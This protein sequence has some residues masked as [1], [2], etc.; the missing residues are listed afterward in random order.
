MKYTISGDTLRL[1]ELSLKKN[2]NV[3][4]YIY[5]KNNDLRGITVDGG[6]VIVD[7]FNQPDLVIEQSAGWLSVQKS[8]GLR[9]ISL[10]ATNEATFNATELNLDKFSVNADESRI[11]VW[12]N[13]QRLEGRADNNSFVRLY[14]PEDIVFKKDKTSI[15]SLTQGSFAPEVIVVGGET[16]A[17]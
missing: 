9:T 6:S 13:V 16:S 14:S 2:Q 15:L 7:Q 4:I 3:N 1:D 5:V 12:S 17:E 8:K 10:N 11:T